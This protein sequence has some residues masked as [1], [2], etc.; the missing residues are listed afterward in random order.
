MGF[1]L[2][3]NL[4]LMMDSLDPYCVPTYQ[5]AKENGTH[6]VAKYNANDP[7]ANIFEHF[8]EC[9]EVSR[10]KKIQFSE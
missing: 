2:Q 7:I 6:L 8:D 9:R 5:Q 1:C 10:S 3:I 4:R